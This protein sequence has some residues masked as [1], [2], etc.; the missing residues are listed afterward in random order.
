M[1]EMLEEESLEDVTEYVE[2]SKQLYEN[3]RFIQHILASDEG[4]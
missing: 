2:E 4:R 3:Y 1:I